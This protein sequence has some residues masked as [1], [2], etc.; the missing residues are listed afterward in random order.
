M[1]A[2]TDAPHAPSAG[3]LSDLAH[4][5][6]EAVMTCPDVRQLTTGPHGRIATHRAGRRLEGVAV[7]GGEIEIGVIVRH[8]RP[9]PEIGEDVRRLVRPLAGRRTIDV[10]IAALADG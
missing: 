10:L 7:R 5:I 6:A 4:R 8:G 2:W 9:L 3:A 1:I